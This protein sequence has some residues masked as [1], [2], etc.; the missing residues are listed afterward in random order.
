MPP[1]SLADAQPRNGAFTPYRAS[2]PL[3]FH[4]LFPCMNSVAPGFT[5]SCRQTHFKVKPDGN[6]H[7]SAQL[8][9]TPLSHPAPQDVSH[10][11][12]SQPVFFT[13][14][15]KHKNMPSAS[16]SDCKP[17]HTHMTAGILFLPQRQSTAENRVTQKP[18]PQLARGPTLSSLARLRAPRAKQP[19]ARGTRRGGFPP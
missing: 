2:Q 7:E 14:A 5:F 3:E 17:L 13:R 6:I 8:P 15:Q 11:Q 1:P 16:R 19:P 12:S 9:G 18:K 10:S 4:R